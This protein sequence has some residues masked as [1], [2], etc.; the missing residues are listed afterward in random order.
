MRLSSPLPWFLVVSGLSACGPDIKGEGLADSGDT[1]ATTADPNDSAD[2]GD[3]GDTDDTSSPPMGDV[4]VEYTVSWVFADATVEL[5]AGDLALSNVDTSHRTWTLWTDAGLELDVSD[6]PNEAPQ[7][8]PV[9]EGNTVNP[10]SWRFSFD[11]T[12]DPDLDAYNAALDAGSAPVCLLANGNDL[13]LQQAQV[14]DP[15]P[16]RSGPVVEVELRITALWTD[17]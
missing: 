15:I 4:T 14:P 2:S 3:S 8:A 13:E 1:D 11:T 7:N 12:T 10:G 16:E 6:L 5:C 17:L 9:G